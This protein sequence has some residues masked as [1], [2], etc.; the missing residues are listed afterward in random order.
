M[1][2]TDNHQE[3]TMTTARLT[4]VHLHADGKTHL[5]DF[6]IVEGASWSAVLMDAARSLREF[7][8]LPDREVVS[9]VLSNEERATNGAT[10]NKCFQPAEWAV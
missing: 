5:C 10:M 7:A 2:A 1:N 3:P 9:A 6:R 4:I 8:A